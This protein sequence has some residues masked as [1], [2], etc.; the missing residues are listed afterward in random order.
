[1]AELSPQPVAIHEHLLARLD[2]AS[3]T[4][5]QRGDPATDAALDAWIG[6]A[7][8]SEPDVF[9][10]P[11]FADALPPPLFRRVGFGGRVPTVEL[12]V[13]V[14]RVPTPGLLRARFATRHV[15]GGL[16]H[17]DGELWDSSGQLVAL[18]R[19]LAIISRR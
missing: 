2:P 7:D 10:L 15:T 3:A 19:Q 14:H 16:V 12:T 11:L 13:H 4:H 6:F 17:E 8:S 1:M 9:A 18:S 5:W